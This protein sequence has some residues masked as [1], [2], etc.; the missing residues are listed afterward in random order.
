MR[1]NLMPL[2]G[3]AIL[4]TLSLVPTAQATD[5][6]SQLFIQTAIDGNQGK[7]NLGKLAE[8]K[9]NS[10]A[11]KSFGAMLVKDCKSA[12]DKAAAVAK[13]VDVTPPT[14]SIVMGMADYL[15]LKEL[16]GDS[17]DK[18][19]AKKIASDQRDDIKAYQEQAQKDDPVGQYAKDSLPTLQKQLQQ[20]EKL[21]QQLQ[22][23]RGSQ[24]TTGR[25]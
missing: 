4:A 16:S 19:F 14:G 23:T 8:E 1:T 24:E 20:A 12:K 17:F 10:P 11:V 22:Q 7:I 5:A 15:K 18:F 13:Q 6:N 3:L 21:E 9:G 2:V 25:K